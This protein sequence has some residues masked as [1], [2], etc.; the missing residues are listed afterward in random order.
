VL[1][2]LARYPEIVQKAC[3]ELEPSN[4]S[5]GNKEREKRIL[6]EDNDALRAAR[7]HLIDAVRNTLAHGLGL[8]GVR[9]PEAM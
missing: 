2:A 6:L 4:L 3:D 9:A 1:L 5:A 7:L 8:L